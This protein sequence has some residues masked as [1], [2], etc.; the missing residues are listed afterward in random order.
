MVG[1]ADDRA[2]TK[3]AARSRSAACDHRF[4]HQT[5][6]PQSQANDQT[7]AVPLFASRLIATNAPKRRP[8]I[9]APYAVI[10]ISF[11]RLR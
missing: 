2:P 5:T 9:S 1:F 10:L 8:L 4:Q 6:R 11:S 7:G 3:A